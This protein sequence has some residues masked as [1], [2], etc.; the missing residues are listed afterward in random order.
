[1]NLY[2]VTYLLMLYISML[3]MSYLFQTLNESRLSCQQNCT[4]LGNR[5]EK[6]IY[7]LL[8]KVFHIYTLLWEHSV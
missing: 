8:I 3:A 5:F 2:L 4:V 6:Q 1:M 7:S